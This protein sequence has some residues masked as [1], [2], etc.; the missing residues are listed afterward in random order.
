MKMQYLASQQMYDRERDVIDEKSAEAGQERH[1]H[2]RE[3][4]YFGKLYH[5]PFI[6]SYSQ[7]QTDLTSASTVLFLFRSTSPHDNVAYDE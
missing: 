3:H 2:R 7:S 6:A 1:Y 4:E 5:L